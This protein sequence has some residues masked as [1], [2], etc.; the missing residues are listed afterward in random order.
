MSG[1]V[2][3]NERNFD[4]VLA[5]HDGILV[6]DFWA[7]WCRPCKTMAPRVA[8]VAAERPELLV[9]KV[10]VARARRLVARYGVRVVPTLMR[11]DG[12]RP[13]ASVVGALSY[14]RLLAALRLDDGSDQLRAGPRAA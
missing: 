3:L 14:D 13:T 5:A 11:F 6:V 7:R 8:R 2:A 1:P 4:S 12:A 9:A 10:D